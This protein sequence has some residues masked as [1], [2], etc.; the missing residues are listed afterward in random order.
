MIR[1]PHRLGVLGIL[2]AAFF[3]AYSASAEG[4][5][6]FLIDQLKNAGDFRLRT[7]AALALGAS[8]DPSAA[9]PLCQALDDP[10]NSVRSAA[11]AG[12]GKLRSPEG[13]PCLRN[14]MNEANAAV[15]SVIER[16][17]NALQ[18]SA[19]P[20]K[21]PAPGPNDTFYIAIGQVTDN[22]G[23][24]DKTVEQLVGAAM[25]DKLLSIQGYAVAPQGESGAAARRVIKQKSLRGYLLQTRVEP[26]RSSSG[27]L[28][29][30]VRVTMWTYPAKSLQGE[31]SPKL[32]MSGASAGDTE[33][34]DSLI[35]MAI[36]KAIESFA[37]VTASTN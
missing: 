37:Q 27:G 33:S 5:V 18:G 19:W 11:A 13:L 30:Q 7:Q 9:A 20:S 2:L 8:D 35:K 32:T 26:P 4:R 15:R 34:E 16:S 12:L 10:S 17:A 28:T 21:P 31:F 25:Q 14:H 23:R 29:I 1:L 36:E 6:G 22:T 24:G 3:A